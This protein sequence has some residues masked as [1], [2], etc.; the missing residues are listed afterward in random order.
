MVKTETIATP[1]RER[2]ALF[3]K[4]VSK[5]L[6]GF[7]LFFW[8]KAWYDFSNS[9]LEITGIFN[10]FEISLLKEFKPS[11]VFSRLLTNFFIIDSGISMDEKYAKYLIKKTRSDYNLIAEQFSGTRSF[12]WKD[13]EPFL[14]YTS[15][16]D[17]VLD[18]G[19]GNGRLF[20][21]LK[22][23]GIDYI[24]V[25][26]S[27]G[28]I[29]EAKKKFPKTRF[30]I[31]DLLNLSFSENTFDKIYCIATLH[32]IPSNELRLKALEEMKRVLRPGGILILTVWNLWQ[33]K[34][35]WKS[36]IKNNLLKLIGSAKM[37]FNDIL[38]PWK[39]KTGKVLV[40]RYI[41]LF[42]KKELKKSAKKT[43]FLVKDIGVTERPE[44]KDN[45]IYI[46]CQK[47]SSP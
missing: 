40:Q 3:L 11:G 44:Q 7:I 21:V 9:T 39:D 42:T 31:Q 43:G 45:N 26:N 5:N 16:G 27:E 46:I 47:Q 38:V 18:L 35:I 36:V 33:R 8:Q 20:S 37:D 10:L 28:L 19:C 13:L 17:K 29:A 2:I 30:E 34:T 32:H 25:D 14:D 22:E 41:H 24:G 15:S 12:F 23:K 1:E 6:L 4:M